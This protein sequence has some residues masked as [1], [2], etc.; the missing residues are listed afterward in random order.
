MYGNIC[1]FYMLL[2]ATF[3]DL[4]IFLAL[5]KFLTI[6]ILARSMIF[7]FEKPF[8]I[9]AWPNLRRIRYLLAIGF[10]TMYIIYIFNAYKYF[11]ATANYSVLGQIKSQNKFS[12]KV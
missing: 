8:Q 10:I 1:T 12:S 4:Y 3:F 7:E 9:L 11:H 5:V 6:W 2:I